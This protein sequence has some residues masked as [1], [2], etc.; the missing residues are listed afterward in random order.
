MSFKG[1]YLPSWA[2]VVVSLLVNQPGETVWLLLTRM[3]SVWVYTLLVLIDNDVSYLQKYQAHECIAMFFLCRLR[4]GSKLWYWNVFLVFQV[5]KTSLGIFIHFYSAIWPI[6]S[7]IQVCMKKSHRFLK[8][9][10]TISIR[11][12]HIQDWTKEHS[13]H[14][15]FQFR[16]SWKMGQLSRLSRIPEQ[17]CKEQLTLKLW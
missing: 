13:K 11:S 16:N 10:N 14:F 2:S 1:C 12:R 15:G 8:K 9:L 6:F 3:Y 4:M 7:H 17:L 5:R